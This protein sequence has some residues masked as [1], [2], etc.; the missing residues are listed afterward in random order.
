MSNL[1][2]NA[3]LKA[4]KTCQIMVKKMEIRTIKSIKDNWPEG[5]RAFLYLMTPKKIM[6]E[7]SGCRMGSPNVF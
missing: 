1:C 4:S 5:P 6:L 3:V 7:L 2:K